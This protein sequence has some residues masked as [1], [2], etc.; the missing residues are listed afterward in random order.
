[1]E[2]TIQLTNDSQVIS[3]V[4]TGKWDS[5]TDKAMA[6]DVMAK[7]AETKLSRVLV[8]MRELQFDLP[9]INMFQRAK[10]LRDQRRG[11]EAVSTR[12][13]LVYTA[14]SKKLDESLKFFEDASQNRGLPYRVFK[15]VDS[16]L[17]WLLK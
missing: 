4:I 14:V 7:V 6:L 8:D 1:M 12:V 13:A 11:F 2:Y 15:N 5:T 17:E 16:A 9:I 3:V 10:E